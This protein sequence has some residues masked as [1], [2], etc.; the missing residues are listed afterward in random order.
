MVNQSRI[1]L[2]QEGNEF[3]LHT[4]KFLSD[5]GFDVKLVSKDGSK[6]MDNINSLHPDA[7]IIDAFMPK[8][9]AL[10][11]LKILSESKME[12]RPAMIIISSVDNPEFESE[13]INAG[14]DYYFLKPIELNML[15]QR[16]TQILK[17]TKDGYKGNFSK[18]VMKESVEIVITDIMREIGVPAHIKGYHYLREAIRLTVDDPELMQAVTKILYPTIAKTNKTTSSRVERAIRHAI[19]VAW[20]RGDVDVLSSYFG[21]TIQDSRGKPTNSEF[22]AMISDKLRLSMKAS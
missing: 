4:A 16:L 8:V 11:V 12:K 3:A 20:D 14:A 22:I 5:Y 13:I 10:G 21:Y 9:D 6:I 18:G 19:E 15:A 7:V 1:M 17:W 2:A